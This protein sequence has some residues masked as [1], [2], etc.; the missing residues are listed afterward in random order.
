MKTGPNYDEQIDAI[1]KLDEKTVQRAFAKACKMSGIS[2]KEPNMKPKNYHPKKVISVEIKKHYASNAS[3]INESHYTKF[4][5]HPEDRIYRDREYIQRLQRHID[6][7]Y[8]LLANDLRLNQKGQDFL[9]DYVFNE[10]SKDIEFEEYLDK[11]G[12]KYEDIAIS[13]N[14]Y[15][16]Q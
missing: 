14:W 4:G 9:F 13:N 3:S 2:I 12:I 5:E 16:R 6:S 1:R 15:H 11:Y 8:D 10:D 7:V